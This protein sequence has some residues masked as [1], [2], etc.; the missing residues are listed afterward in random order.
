MMSL[1]PSHTDENGNQKRSIWDSTKTEEP[2][3]KQRCL[4]DEETAHNTDFSSEEEELGIPLKALLTHTSF[5]EDTFAASV[6]VVESFDAIDEATLNTIEEID[7]VLEEQTEPQEHYE[8]IS[9][10]PTDTVSEASATKE[11]EPVL[12][13]AEMHQDEDHTWDELAADAKNNENDLK[14]IN[15]AI[16]EIVAELESQEA[17]KITQCILTHFQ[18]QQKSTEGQ[19]RDDDKALTANKTMSLTL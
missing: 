16:S 5:E 2:R 14:E 3:K 15:D 17:K 4:K 12:L 11:S 10:E 7:G 9:L 1:R 6:Q 13:T 18:N 8:A 19:R